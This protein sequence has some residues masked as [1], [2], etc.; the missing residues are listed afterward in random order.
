MALIGP[1]VGVA[2]HDDV[3]HAEDLD[4]VLDRGRGPAGH[5]HV[6]NDVAHVANDEEIAGL[7]ARDE[8]GDD[9]RV[10]AGDEERLRVLAA[11]GEAAKERAVG[12]KVLRVKR[13]DPIDQ[14][15]HH[16]HRS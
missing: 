12:R 11:L 7:G 2:A 14:L 13:V 6:R 15:V 3:R 4:R 8:I 16:V 1:A 9:A 5:R 10:R